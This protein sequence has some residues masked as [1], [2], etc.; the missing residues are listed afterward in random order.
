MICALVGRA[1]TAATL[2]LGDDALGVLGRLALTVGVEEGERHVA[3]ADD[4][5]AGR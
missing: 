3:Q 2:A 5:G 1:I 4:P